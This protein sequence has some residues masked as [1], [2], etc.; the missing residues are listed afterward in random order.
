MQ[1]V[2][3]N[4]IKR[5][6]IAP[7]YNDQDNVSHGWDKSVGY[8]HRNPNWFGDMKEFFMASVNKPKMSRNFISFRTKLL[9]KQV[10]GLVTQLSSIRI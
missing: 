3:N 6:E 7:A 5:K 2:S 4:G 1:T 10:R 8:V 9:V